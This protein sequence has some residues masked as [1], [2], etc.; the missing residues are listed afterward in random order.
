MPKEGARVPTQSELVK[1]VWCDPTNNVWIYSN[2][3]RTYFEVTHRHI[4][5]CFPRLFPVEWA[6]DEATA[7][8]P[9]GAAKAAGAMMRAYHR[10][11]YGVRQ[12]KQEKR[13]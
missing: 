3:S 12:P 5:G 1:Q 13:A 8:T 7:N 11:R 10:S 2:K 6:P 9:G 4:G